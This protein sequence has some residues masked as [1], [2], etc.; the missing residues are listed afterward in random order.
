MYIS[1]KNAEKLETTNLKMIRLFIVSDIHCRSVFLT[2]W[3][4]IFRAE[5]TETY[6]FRLFFFG[7]F[8]HWVSGFI[9]VNGVAYKCVWI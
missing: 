5:L 6:S 2:P 1:V 8:A 9:R 4:C 7:D 3:H